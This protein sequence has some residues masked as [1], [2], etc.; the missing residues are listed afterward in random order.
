M[1]T[2]RIGYRTV[3]LSI[4][5]VLLALGACDDDDD[6]DAV[7]DAGAEDAGR[8]EDAEPTEDAGPMEDAEP[9]DDAGAM[10]DAALDG[11]P[12][13]A[14]DAAVPPDAG[15]AGAAT[16]RDVTLE[17][18][19]M[20]PHVGQLM[21]FQIRS[22]QDDTI[23]FR[24]ILASLPDVDFTYEMPNSTPPG[25]H[26]LDFFADLNMNQS[27]DSPP[28]DHAWRENI[29]ASGD[30]TVEFPHNTDFTDIELMAPGE[31]FTFEATGMDPHLDQLFELRVINATSGQVV[32]RYVLPSIADTEF[33]FTIPGILEEG[34]Q[35]QIDYFADLSENGSY[36][37]PPTDHAWRRMVNADAAG[38]TLEF[39]HD[40]DFTDVEF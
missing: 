22:S 34:Q 36:D 35:Y 40:T 15:D 4:P 16:F 8:M 33:S 20:D 7:L 21:E 14:G 32:G 39:P 27:F 30:V 18:T 31:D 11:G 10:A 23:A 1:T 9:V 12:A 28:D 26:Q 29:A 19:D 38:A 13:D 5:L 24:G 37:A 2:T 6:M 3:L 25:E 17:M